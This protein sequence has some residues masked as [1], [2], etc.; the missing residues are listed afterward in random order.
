M[1]DDDR[2]LYQRPSWQVLHR[3]FKQVGIKA[4]AADLGLGYSTVAKWQE[5]PESLSESG[6]RN[7]LDRLDQIRQ[8]LVD[9]GRHDEAVEPIR[10][11]AQ[12]AGYRLVK[13]SDLPDDH[14]SLL[15]EVL[16]LAA[17]SGDVQ[18]IFQEAISDNIITHDER[19]ALLKELREAQEQA[20]R[21]ELIVRIKKI[22]A[23]R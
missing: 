17:E 23:E 8:T 20:A 7:P 11:L 9:A 2:E 4:V 22:F 19:E 3:V 6:S 14:D 15:R 12:R 21:V 16:T 1:A 5:D 10:W 13:S 18:R